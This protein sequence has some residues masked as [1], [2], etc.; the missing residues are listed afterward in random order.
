[1]VTIG[2]ELTQLTNAT[3]QPKSE[4]TKCLPFKM[5][6]GARQVQ[7]QKIHSTDMYNH[8]I[9]KL[10]AKEDIMLIRCT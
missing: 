4:D 10:T 1:M 8:P 9:V 6:D 5:A 3:K 2:Q 7:Q